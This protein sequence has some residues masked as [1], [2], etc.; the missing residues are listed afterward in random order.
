VQL[1]KPLVHSSESCAFQFTR[2]VN[3][4]ASDAMIKLWYSWAQYYLAH[5]KDNTPS[6]PTAPTPITASID[7]NT[8]TLSFTDPHPELVKG[9]AVEGPG[10]NDA[11]TEVGIH[12]GDAVILKIASDQKSVILSQVANIPSANALHLRAPKALP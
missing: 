8:A 10:L 5:W 3:D 2:P 12:Q 11:Q 9:M 1:S 7:A 6:A 4:Y